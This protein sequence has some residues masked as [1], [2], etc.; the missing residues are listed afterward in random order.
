MVLV[1]PFFWFRFKN[2]TYNSLEVHFQDKNIHWWST[3]YN[4]LKN[5]QS[6]PQFQFIWGD[7]VYV[8][9]LYP[10]ILHDVL[11]IIFWVS[12]FQYRLRLPKKSY[13]DKQTKTGVFLEG[14]LWKLDKVTSRAGDF[15]YWIKLFLEKCHFCY[16]QKNLPKSVH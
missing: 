2:I 7:F 16:V 13:F 1:K 4:F 5:S 10:K 12:C 9:K 8:F 14:I 3:R 11:T 6:H 15:V